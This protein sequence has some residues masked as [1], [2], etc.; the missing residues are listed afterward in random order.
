MPSSFEYDT[1]DDIINI[2]R[3]QHKAVDSTIKLLNE[4]SLGNIDNIEKIKQ[5]P[6]FATAIQYALSELK[7]EGILITPLIFNA[8]I[9][10][11]RFA[12]RV[13]LAIKT[14]TNIGILSDE[15]LTI[16]A[17]YAQYSHRMAIII[18]ELCNADILVENQ[19]LVVQVAEYSDGIATLLREL[20]SCEIK[21]DNNYFKEI[22]K[23]SHHAHE[24][25]NIINQMHV[26]GIATS[27]NILKVIQSAQ[28]LSGLH[29]ILIKI[30]QAGLMND[31]I[32]AKKNFDNLIQYSQFL[33]EIRQQI[34]AI[35]PFTQE[36]FDKIVAEKHDKLKFTFLL[37]T[38]SR[39]GASSS[40]CRFFGTHPGIL[41]NSK[42]PNH[43][44]SEKHLLNVISKFY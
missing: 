35:N 13:S 27:K 3:W 17:Q 40:I 12:D 37:G 24:I 14:L 25:A 44:L 9:Y 16:L 2:E 42:I 36:T 28:H 34:D 39:I 18:E 5:N 38:D 20:K 6:Q 4:L 19:N 8:L 29:L 33:V 15:M 43:S 21:L 23:N 30:S 11:P 41:P 31:K 10:N 32:Q 22:I 7:Q 1:T 26:Y